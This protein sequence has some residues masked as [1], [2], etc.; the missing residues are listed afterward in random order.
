M[1]QVDAIQDMWEKAAIAFEEIC[2]ESLQEGEIRD[3]A[4]VQKK[5]EESG[6]A[7]FGNERI[8]EDK[9]K[10]ARDAGLG[11]LNYL[12]MLVGIAS[13]A[14]TFVRPVMPCRNT[15]SNH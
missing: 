7:S 11:A 15:C 14:A 8:T 10:S 12:K 9:W 2:K 13:Q 1:T 5:I 3:F 6:Q 4:D